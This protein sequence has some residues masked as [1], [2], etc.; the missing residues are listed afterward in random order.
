LLV[1]AEAEGSSARL[2]SDVAPTCDN[3]TREFTH[4]WP[5]LWRRSHG[6]PVCTAFGPRPTRP[7]QRSL[8]VCLKLK[9]ANSFIHMSHKRRVLL[10]D[11]RLELLEQVRVCLLLL[12]K[13]LLQARNFLLEVVNLF[14]VVLFIL[15]QLCI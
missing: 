11:H 5:Q 14:Q 10:R 9:L 3:I 6:A 12:V 4:R 15:Q 7:F 1:D 13:P 8:F 2:R